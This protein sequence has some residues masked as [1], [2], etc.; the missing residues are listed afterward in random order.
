M[1]C[2]RPNGALR[3]D[4]N[5]VLRSAV[6]CDCSPQSGSVTFDSGE[7]WLVSG[8]QGV[9]DQGVNLFPVALHESGHGLGLDHHQASPAI[10]NA[11]LT[12][13]TKDLTS[14]DIHGIQFLYGAGTDDREHRG[15]R[16]DRAGRC[17]R[18]SRRQPGCGGA[19]RSAPAR[20]PVRR[21][22]GTL[23]RL[24]GRQLRTKAR[25]SAFSTSAFTVSMPW[26]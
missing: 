21:E 20:P 7:N 18:P 23:P 16:V 9:S 26:L 24:R 19:Y 8:S 5:E 4:T 11:V 22:G 13:S 14:S 6:V 15:S 17:A 10:M 1:F 2:A 25:R 12:A 3:A